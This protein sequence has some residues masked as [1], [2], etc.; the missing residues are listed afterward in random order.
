MSK[1]FMDKC[2]LTPHLATIDV[3]FIMDTHVLIDVVV[4]S[5][6]SAGVDWFIITQNTD[7]ANKAVSMVTSYRD[8]TCQRCVKSLVND[9]IMNT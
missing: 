1:K 5:H 9:D 6:L 4:I 2:T 3:N 8:I 7:G